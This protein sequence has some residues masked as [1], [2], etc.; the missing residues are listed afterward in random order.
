MDLGSTTLDLGLW[1]VK[2]NFG[3]FILVNNYDM[4]FRPTMTHFNLPF[5]VTHLV[6][7]LVS[8]GLVQS[9]FDISE[10]Q[11]S[12]ALIL[13]CGQ[14]Q[15]YR[16]LPSCVLDYS[17]DI[18]IFI[19]TNS[20]TIKAGELSIALLFVTP[21]HHSKVSCTIA[22]YQGDDVVDASPQLDVTYSGYKSSEISGL[23]KRNDKNVYQ[24]LVRG[25]FPWD[26]MN[27]KDIVCIDHNAEVAAVKTLL[28]ERIDHEMLRFSM[29]LFNPEKDNVHVVATVSFDVSPEIIFLHYFGWM[30]CGYDSKALPIYLEQ[31]KTMKPHESIKVKIK[32]MYATYESSSKGTK[33]AICGLSESSLW[34]AESKTW[35]PM[36]PLVLTIHNISDRWVTLND[37]QPVALGLII[38]CQDS[39]CEPADSIYFDIANNSLHWQEINIPGDR[40]IFTWPHH[41]ARREPCEQEC[42]IY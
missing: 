10:I 2:A 24:L 1:T 14:S 15:Q 33:I 36:T 31:Q 28:V 12:C 30:S 8:F 34:I 19:K 41:I 23:A 35:Q 27:V 4:N 16:I 40:S 39:A 5:S 6:D 18:S 17:S 11:M 38:S 42:M 21:I 26:F 7:E 37:N 32:T 20:R 25:K 9:F 3:R 29:T 13:Q 22:T